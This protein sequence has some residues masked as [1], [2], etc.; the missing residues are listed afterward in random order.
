M[1]RFALQHGVSTEAVERSVHLAYHELPNPALFQ[2]FCARQQADLLGEYFL[3][4]ERLLQVLPGSPAFTEDELVRK[5][6]TYLPWRSGAFPP[7]ASGQ[8]HP[9]ELG[10]IEFVRETAMPLRISV[11]R[12]ASIFRRPPN[13]L[14]LQNPAPGSD[15]VVQ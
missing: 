7:A 13:P 1:H 12:S 9:E 14:L 15:P 3:R 11:R 6:D 10:K 5:Y 8:D 2:K 4:K